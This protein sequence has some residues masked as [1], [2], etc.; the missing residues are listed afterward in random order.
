MALNFSVSATSEKSALQS[1]F[2]NWTSH[3]LCDVLQFS[4]KFTPWIRPR[5]KL[6]FPEA[7]AEMVWSAKYLSESNSWERKGEKAGWNR[8]KNQMAL[9]G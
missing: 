1:Q 7:D 8:G 6:D 3:T 9:E 2:P 5:H 4:N